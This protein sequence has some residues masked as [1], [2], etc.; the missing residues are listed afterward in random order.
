MSKVDRPPL[1]SATLQALAGVAR[2]ELPPGRH[3]T[4]TTALQGVFSLF[5]GLDQ[6]EI[7]ETPPANAYDAR[8]E[9]K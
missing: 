8:W 4:L 5:D 7:G 6:V 9:A 1:N 2:L 3:E